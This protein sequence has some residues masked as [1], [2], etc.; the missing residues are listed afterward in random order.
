MP[1]RRALHHTAARRSG[2]VYQTQNGAR[3]MAP[4]TSGVLNRIATADAMLLYLLHAYKLQWKIAFV[5]ICSGNPLLAAIEI[6]RRDVLFLKQISTDV[7][8]MACI[9]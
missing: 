2:S 8:N 5:Q 3:A 1:L 6:L 9:E 4:N 7:V